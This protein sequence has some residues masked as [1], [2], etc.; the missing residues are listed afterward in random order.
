MV[1][2]PRKRF[3]FALDTGLLALQS[4]RTQAAQE[5]L[6]AEAAVAAEQMA[7]TA[8]QRSISK[9]EQQ[10]RGRHDNMMTRTGPE[11]LGWDLDHLV[12]LSERLRQTR[13]AE[14]ELFG[15]LRFA[16]Q[17]L[18]FRREEFAA[19]HVRVRAIERLREL[20][21]ARFV[22]DRAKR[23]EKVLEEAAIAKQFVRIG[24]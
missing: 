21:K 3:H 7:L 13:L 24:G 9:I 20:R 12:G 18:G 11:T 22:K 6:A 14:A 16:E 4:Q 8:C 23:E 17:Y 2:L 19:F 5:I 10:I 1:D 15:K